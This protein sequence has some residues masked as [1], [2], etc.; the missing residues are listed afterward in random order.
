MVPTAVGGWG[1]TDGSWRVLD[2]TDTDGGPRRLTQG[3]SPSTKKCAGVS[4]EGVVPQRP[5]RQASP[6]VTPPPAPIS[7]VSYGL[8]VRAA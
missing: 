3:K 4:I 1:A 8:C 6:L 7:M 5:V 2:E